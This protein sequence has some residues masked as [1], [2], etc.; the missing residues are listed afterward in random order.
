ME[1]KWT[2]RQ[3]KKSDAQ[4][5]FAL[6]LIGWLDTYVNESVGV[7]REFILNIRLSS[8]NYKF[9]TEDCKY[10]NFENNDNNL[11][12]VAQDPNGVIIGMIHANRIDGKQILE[13]LYL[14]KEFHGTGLAQELTAKFI[15]WEDKSMDSHVGLVKYN[16]RAKRFYQKLGFTELTAEYMLYDKIPCID[17]VK[18]NVKEEK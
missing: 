10:E 9:Y 14:Y 8:L 4:A 13:G 18:K 1:N 15:E 12:Y 11:H 7:T 16:E 17:L 6:L 5:M 2:I 3:T